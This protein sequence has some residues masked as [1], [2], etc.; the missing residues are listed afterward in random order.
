MVPER[1]LLLSKTAV[2]PFDNTGSSESKWF[3]LRSNK[4]KPD[5]ALISGNLPE[6][7]L[8][9]NT[10]SVNDVILESEEEN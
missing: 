4:Y 10:I 5:A 2:T 1:E 9:D 3:S 8:W 6:S 7:S